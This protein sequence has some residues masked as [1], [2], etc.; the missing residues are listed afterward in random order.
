[1]GAEHKK[2]LLV[3]FTLLFICLVAGSAFVAIQIQ[4]MGI[5]AILI[6]VSVI[7]AIDIRWVLRANDKFSG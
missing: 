3:I 2:A 5:A 1:M 6:A 4:H 7:L